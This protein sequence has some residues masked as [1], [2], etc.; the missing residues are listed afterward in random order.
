VP[1]FAE[2]QRRGLFICSRFMF[3]PENH[4]G[5]L[6]LMRD[7]GLRREGG[8]TESASPARAT[9]KLGRRILS[10]TGRCLSLNP[11]YTQHEGRHEKFTVFS[12]KAYTQ[13]PLVWPTS[14]FA[15]IR[16]VNSLTVP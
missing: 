6:A 16:I 8:G 1:I 9:K 5:Y 12:G 11:N 2:A 14:E 10:G 15:R 3:C 4:L 13:E 7:L